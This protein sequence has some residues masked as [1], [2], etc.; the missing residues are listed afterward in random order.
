MNSPVRQERR[1]VRFPIDLP[2]SI[3]LE[4]EEMHVQSENISVGGILLS[5]AFLIPEGSTV[6]LKI[7]VSHL[8][9]LSARGKVVRVQANTSGNFAVAVAFDCLELA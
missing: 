9:L 2:V 6:D 1:D 3:R 4:R 7:G 5:S 8:K